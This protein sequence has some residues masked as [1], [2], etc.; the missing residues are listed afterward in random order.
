MCDTHEP[1][2]QV[3]PNSFTK[4]PPFQ[5]LEKKSPPIFVYF[6]FPLEGTLFS[7]KSHVRNLILDWYFLCMH[8]WAIF[9]I[10]YQALENDIK[11][12]SYKAGKLHLFNVKFQVFPR[13]LNLKK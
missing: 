12:L 13:F 2:H 1:L 11:L 5:I 10:I 4:S 9:L 8:F 3:F 7:Q 6:N